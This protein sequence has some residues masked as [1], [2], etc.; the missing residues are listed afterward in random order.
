MPA[1]L[2]PLARLNEWLTAIK[3][4]YRLFAPAPDADGVV[5]FREVDDPSAIAVQ[6]GVTA[7]PMKALFMPT[8]E[9]LFKYSYKGDRATV[10]VT[11]V[12]TSPFVV[13]GA[14]LCDA[15]AQAIVDALWSDRDPDPYYQARRQAGTIV[16]MTCAEALPECFC[17]SIAHA[18]S[19]PE[20]AD[21]VMTPLGDR[22]L[23]ESLTD[24]GDKLL[25]AT[26]NLLQDATEDDTA[27]RE[28]FVVRVADAMP[29][30][31]NVANITE[32][33]QALYNDETFWRSHSRQCIGCGVCSYMCPTCTC[34]DVLDDA[35]GA[36]GYRYRCWDTCQFRGFC[37][38]ASGHDPKPEQWMKQRNRIGHKL[39]YSVERFGMVSCVGCGRC[40]KG[41]PGNMDI[42]GLIEEFS[43][44][45][46]ASE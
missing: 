1:K 24:K 34:F 41:C 18:L 4:S 17:E 13:F 45:K 29:H 9:V 37:T 14:R 15:K 38:E 40:I 25:Q 22:Y 27:A 3:S 6:A 46:V 39:W 28:A 36:N 2:L 20:G 11:E 35:V 23:L 12:D 8:S 33:L 42:S 5:A 21:V 31:G 43:R 16:A 44:E 10:A 7:E 30:Y 26:D 19:A 32:R